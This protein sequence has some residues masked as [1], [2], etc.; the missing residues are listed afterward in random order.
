MD[1]SAQIDIADLPRA[2]RRSRGTRRP[3]TPVLVVALL[4]DR[5][6]QLEQALTALTREHEALDQDTTG[7][8]RAGLYEAD[9]L[10]VAMAQRDIKGTIWK[11]CHPSKY[12]KKCD[13][14]RRH[15]GVS[16]HAYE[17]VAMG[18]QEA[19]RPLAELRE[20][21]KRL[22]DEVTQLSDSVNEVDDLQELQRRTLNDKIEA[23]LRLLS[24]RTLVLASHRKRE[25]ETRANKE[26]LEVRQAA[27][28]DY[29]LS[30][31][32]GVNAASKHTTAMG[33]LI[34][35]I[36]EE[37]AFLERE[38]QSAAQIEEKQRVRVESLQLQRDGT[39]AKAE[40]SFVAKLQVRMGVFQAKLSDISAGLRDKE[41]PLRAAGER[42]LGIAARLDAL[43]ESSSGDLVRGVEDLARG[44]AMQKYEQKKT[45]EK[46]EKRKSWERRKAAGRSY[47]P[48]A[49]CL[50]LR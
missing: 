21:A 26:Q 1:S 38:I 50:G 8:C 29:P 19:L 27:G 12:T 48:C 39:A 31:F 33:F 10:L 49:I 16:R 23:G 30:F 32:P 22:G 6:Q 36:T 15:I 25:Q 14:L 2:G 7:A 28:E 5:M 42:C 18:C 9:G 13:M 3:T 11:L 4:G 40:R 44:I 43:R 46:E 47:T 17:T 41:V 34:E 35:R 20:R 37:V 45:R 24:D